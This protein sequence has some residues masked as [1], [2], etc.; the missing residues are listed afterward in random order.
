MKILTMQDQ[1]SHHKQIG[2]P[3]EE[4]YAAQRV[5]AGG[6]RKS[7]R[8]P[9]LRKEKADRPAPRSS[10]VARS[11]TRRPRRNL[12]AATAARKNRPQVLGWDRAERSAPGKSAVSRPHLR[13]PQSTCSGRGPAYEAGCRDLKCAGWQGNTTWIKCCPSF[14]HDRND[15][16]RPGR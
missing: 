3:T 15:G 4:G 11:A 1:F 14:R 16:G 5:I 2:Y 12:C 7:C 13:Y 10:L 8:L 9:D 6:G